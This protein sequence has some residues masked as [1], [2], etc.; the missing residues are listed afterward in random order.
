MTYHNIG[1][2]LVGLTI[3]LIIAMRVNSNWECKLKLTRE[4]HLEAMRISQ[5]Q[6]V[7][8]ANS[9]LSQLEELQRGFLVMKK[10]VDE[11]A[12][13][14]RIHYAREIGLG[15]HNNRPLGE[16]VTAYLAVER[17]YN[18]RLDQQAWPDTRTAKIVEAER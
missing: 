8:S 13:Y 4:K 14:L 5:D 2:I 17:E 1:L 18:K 11:I 15:Y 10:D 9:R 6:S 3:G 7:R 16:I 12:L